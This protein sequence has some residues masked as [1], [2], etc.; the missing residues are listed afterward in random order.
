[1]IE[2]VPFWEVDLDDETLPDEKREAAEF[3]SKMDYEG[4]VVG[5]LDYGGPIGFPVELHG[6]A[7]L[8]EDA[9][10][11]LRRAIDKWANNRGVAA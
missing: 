9:L 8:A 3:L 2:T 10:N 11:R 1:M 4:G 6:E 5:M 7:R